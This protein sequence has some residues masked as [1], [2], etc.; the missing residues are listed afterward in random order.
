MDF[1]SS[2]SLRSSLFLYFLSFSFADFPA[3]F[4]AAAADEA[5]E[6]ESD[7]VAWTPLLAAALKE[8]E[9]EAFRQPKVCLCLVV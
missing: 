1:Y 9:R 7:S 5:V 8:E 3:S 6:I 2:G 4:A